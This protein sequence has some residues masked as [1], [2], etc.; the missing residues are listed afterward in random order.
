MFPQRGNIKEFGNL[1]QSN[2]PESGSLVKAPLTNSKPTSDLKNGILDFKEKD[3]LKKRGPSTVEKTHPV[4]IKRLTLRCFQVLILDIQFSGSH[5]SNDKIMV[6]F[7]KRV[8]L[9]KS[10]IRIFSILYSTSI[11]FL[12]LATTACLD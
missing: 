6:N 8:G 5:V 4:C 1:V 10:I 12:N 3:L 2:C 9:L 11:Y 7:F